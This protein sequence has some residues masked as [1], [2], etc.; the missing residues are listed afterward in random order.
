MVAAAAAVAT[1]SA[2]TCSAAPVGITILQSRVFV[3]VVG[4]EVDGK[5]G[6]V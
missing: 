1:C 3:A 2:A 6:L 4:R 5:K